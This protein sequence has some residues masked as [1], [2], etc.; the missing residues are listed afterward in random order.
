MSLILLIAINFR[1]ILKQSDG[2]PSKPAEVVI[3]TERDWS[4]F[5]ATCPPSTRTKLKAEAIKFAE[6]TVVAVA[7]GE[8][9]DAAGWGED[10]RA[11]ILRTDWSGDDLDVAYSVVETDTQQDRARYPI[12]V[13]RTR[14]A[15]KV[16]FHK[17][18]IAEGG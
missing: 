9:H 6:E 2:G 3:Q 16:S 14:K 15:R 4:A 11:G 13:I 7:L 12:H 5:L 10:K 17:T 18:V 8:N 1:T